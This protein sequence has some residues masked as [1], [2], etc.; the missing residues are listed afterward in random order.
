MASKKIYLHLTVRV[1]HAQLHEFNEFW[2]KESLPRWLA[3]GARHIGS[4]VNYVGGVYGEIIRLFEFDSLSHFE[5]FQ[6]SLTDSEDGRSIIKK[7]DRFN[8][9]VEQ[10]LLRAIYE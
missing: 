5:K 8:V 6:D 10:K 9:V 1:P 4:Y 7:I 3:N 2:G